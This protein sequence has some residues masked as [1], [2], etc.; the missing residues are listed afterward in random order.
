MK[1][2]G[3]DFTSRPSKS[4][5][6]TAVQCELQGDTLEYIELANWSNFTQF[7]EF[8]SSPGEWI[9]GIDF[10]FGQ[11]RALIKNTNLPDTWAAYVSKFAS[12]EREQFRQFLEEYKQHRVSGDKEH[13][14]ATDKMF[15]GV[16]PQK[17]YGVPV[18]LMFF[19][20]SPRLLRSNVHIP[21]LNP[22]GDPSRIAVEA[23]PGALAR[24]VIGRESYKSDDKKKQSVQQREARTK[25]LTHLSSQQFSDDFGFRVTAPQTLVDDPSGD[26]LDALLCAVQAAWAWTKRKENYGIPH[27]A[28]PIEG[29]IAHPETQLSNGDKPR[30]RTGQ[31]SLRQTLVETTLKWQK[32]FGI[33]PAI[34]SAISEYD[35]AILVGM[36]EDEYAA[37]MQHVTAV[38]K[39]FDFEFNGLRYQVKGNRPSGK[40]GSK[41]TLVPKAKN[42]LWDKLIWILYDTEYTIVEAWL[43]D[44][45]AYKKEFSDIDRLS[46]ENMRNGRSI[47]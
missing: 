38:Q 26:E 5:P 10:P 21:L 3:I 35:A 39:G 47:K 16:S 1:I 41:E 8:L 31:S 11:S 30:P 12:M 36:T 22:S 46:Q 33:A 28:D 42:F 25:I 9:S 34:T 45:E 24:M 13:Q 2:F 19:E 15:G 17:L 4:K 43:W 7:E 23:Y 14:R 20:G 44:V 37:A 6:I 29:W 40:P 27:A 18:G 32:R